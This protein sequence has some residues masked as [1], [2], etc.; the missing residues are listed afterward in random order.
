[1]SFSSV[2]ATTRNP[3]LDKIFAEE[4]LGAEP[5][6]ESA[7]RHKLRFGQLRSDDEGKQVRMGFGLADEVVPLPKK[8]TSV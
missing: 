5:I 8:R 2:V 4:S 6:S 1:M 3:T 7:L